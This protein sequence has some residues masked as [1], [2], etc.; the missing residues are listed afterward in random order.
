MDRLTWTLK[1]LTGKGKNRIREHGNV[2]EVLTIQD[3]GLISAT[4]MPPFPPIRSV[5]TGEWRWFDDI[6]FEVI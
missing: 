4:P 6:N 1:G 3:I 2:W 5:Q